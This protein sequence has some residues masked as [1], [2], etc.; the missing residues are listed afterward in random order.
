ML[1]RR[2][3]DVDDVAFLD[4][5]GSGLTATPPMSTRPFCI[6]FGGYAVVRVLNMRMAQSRFCM[7]TSMLLLALR[8]KV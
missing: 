4:V 3:A 2:L 6:R 7:R 1:R 8:A 5:C